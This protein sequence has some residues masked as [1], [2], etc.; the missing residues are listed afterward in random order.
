[1]PARFQRF[2]TA[3]GNRYRDQVSTWS[4]WNGRTARASRPR[5]TR[6]R[7]RPSIRLFAKALPQ[8]FLAG[9]RGLRA[10][11]NGS[12]R[13]LMGETEPRGTTKAVP[14]LRFLR[15]LLASRGKLPADGYA[16]HAYTTRSGPDCV[17]SNRDDVTIGVLS[18]LTRA[19]D[20]YGRK[21]RIRRA[22]PVYLTE[23]GIQ[24]KP[25][26][27]IGVS[28]QQ[29]A[30]F[31][32]ISEWIAWRNPRVA[33]F[34]QY[35]MRDDDP[36][37]GRL[38]A[39][40]RLR[41]RAARFERQ[42]EAVVFRLPAA[43]GGRRTWQAGLL[44]GLCASEELAHEGGR[45]DPQAWLRA[46]GQAEDRHHEHARLLA[47]RHVRAEGGAVPRGL[48]CVQRSPDSRVLTQT[49][50]TYPEFVHAVTQGSQMCS[51]CR[52]RLSHGSEP[53]RPR[54][55]PLPH[56][57]GVDDGPATMDESLELARLA[58]RDGT[59]TV[60]ATPHVR[61]DFFTDVHQLPRRVRELNA[62]LRLEGVPLH[63]VQGGE[64]GPAWFRLDARGL[65]L[66][67][68]ARPVRPLDPLEPP[69]KS[70]AGA[71][72]AA[73]E[74]EGAR[75]AVVLAHPERSAG[76]LTAGC[77]LLRE[78]LA[79]GTLTQISVSSLLG[80][81]GTEAQVAARHFVDM[82]MAH[83]VAS[84][85]HSARRPPRLAREWIACWQTARRSPMH[86]ASSRQ[87]PAICWQKASSRGL[88]T[89]RREQTAVTGCTPRHP[90]V[91]RP[92]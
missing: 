78:E 26:P 59:R 22:M 9:D 17:P 84:D 87:D 53:R 88:L 4:I 5:S 58:V 82:R 86:A 76:V 55:D 27:Y 79:A 48:G 70:L 81:H 64:V 23:F 80:H 32:S 15:G 75:F 1:M 71:L 12:D 29:Q 51:I 36:A 7:Q 35:L 72:E 92:L 65:D 8:L 11:G 16:H 56:P 13:L 73:A 3:V 10:S 25:D 49:R 69:F 46:L 21:G 74:L 37:P 83:F 31:R 60:V 6:A 40:L 41:V 34:S 68:T 24:S 85:A 19:L 52:E 61:E 62:R 14:P 2:V 67:A 77:R 47:L 66:V 30:E 45:A 39:L 18:R 63:V 43:A 50:R 28:Y 33:A 89:L 38:R 91:M 90:P 20:Y 57:P 54:G 44:L 42:G